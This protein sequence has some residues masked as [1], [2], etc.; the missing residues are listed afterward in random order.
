MQIS[1][2]HGAQQD[3]VA[4]VIA[5]SRRAEWR[6][7][8][9][10][11]RTR[12]WREHRAAARAQSLA[13][14]GPPWAAAVDGLDSINSDF[15]SEKLRI[16]YNKAIRMIRSEKPCSDTTVGDPDPPPGEAAEEQRKGRETIN[17][18]NRQYKYRHT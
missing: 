4:S 9:A 13:V 1:G 5:R 12:S 6:G 18:K 2:I 14:E 17:T 11:Q 7:A 16:R 8:K 10:A 15:R 3:V